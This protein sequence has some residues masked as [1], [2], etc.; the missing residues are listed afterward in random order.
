MDS[1]SKYRDQEELPSATES[2]FAN[3]PGGGFNALYSSN[4]EPSFGTHWDLDSFQISQHQPAVYQHP[5]SG[6]QQNSSHPS[7]APQVPEL[8]GQ[9]G[10]FGLSYTRNAAPFE[11]PTF[12][13][14]SGHPY[15]TS[16]YDTSLNYG[17]QQLIN[18]SNFGVP[19]VPDLAR[20]NSQNETVSPQALQSYPT[21]F[22]PGAGVHTEF[23][24]C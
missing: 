8:G 22:G 4:Q 6:W 18:P 13:P 10:A 17:N 1:I 19:E 14:R 20:G 21:S 5:E 23:Q 7:N 11:F 24:V 2:S 9:P 15:S 12:N 3:G 16:S